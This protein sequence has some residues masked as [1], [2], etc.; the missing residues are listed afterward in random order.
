MASLQIWTP[1]LQD[2]LEVWKQEFSTLFNRT[3]LDNNDAEYMNLLNELNDREN[4]ITTDNY[5]CDNF[6]NERILL[7]EL[8]ETIAKLKSGKAT[9]LDQIP[10][11]VIKNDVLLPY[12]CHF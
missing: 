9:G 11:E 10:N 12:L 4:E 8:K 5:E 1:P 6:L 2:T 3:D 7:L